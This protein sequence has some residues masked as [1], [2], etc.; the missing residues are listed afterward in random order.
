[1]FWNGPAVISYPVPVLDSISNFTTNSFQLNM[2]LG[3]S[4][5]YAIQYGP[6][7]FASSGLMADTVNALTALTYTV[8]NLQPTC[9]NY[10]VYFQ[11]TCQKVWVGPFTINSPTPTID[12]VIRLL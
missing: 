6:Q 2:Q 3:G 11:D 9:G 5:A 8:S 12:S 7:G 1:M 10:D 4:G